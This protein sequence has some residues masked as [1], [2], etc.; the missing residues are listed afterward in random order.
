M[1]E[2]NIYGVPLVGTTENYIHIS[3]SQ[4]RNSLMLHLSTSIIVHTN[5]ILWIFYVI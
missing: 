4:T 3:L 2:K 5:K 1:E